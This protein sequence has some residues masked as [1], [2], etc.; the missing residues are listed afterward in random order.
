VSMGVGVS[1]SE[2]KVRERRHRLATKHRSGIR[3][4]EATSEEVEPE[5]EALEHDV[6]VEAKPPSRRDRDAEPTSLREPEEE[7]LRTALAALVG[8]VKTR[9]G[10]RLAVERFDGEPVADTEL[11]PLL[12][13]AGFLA[14]PRRVVLRP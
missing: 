8:H 13:E 2:A 3:S 5:H 10:K 11:M 4:I 6:E 7:W 1:A 9:G 14:G 12:L